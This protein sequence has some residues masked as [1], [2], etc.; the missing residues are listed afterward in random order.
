MGKPEEEM[1]FEGV[2]WR[3]IVRYAHH[4]KWSVEDVNQYFLGR[5][6]ATLA[7]ALFYERRTNGR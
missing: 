7:R 3:M 2:W 5:A 1:D 6:V 4:W